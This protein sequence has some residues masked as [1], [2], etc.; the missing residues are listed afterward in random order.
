MGSDI[1]VMDQ[2]PVVLNRFGSIWTS[3]ATSRQRLLK[4]PP[5]S[6]H[7]GKKITILISLRRTVPQRP[8]SGTLTMFA[9]LMAPI[10][11]GFTEP[12]TKN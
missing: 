4:Q 9:V 7:R 11:P 12:N 6:N 2:F 3:P 8:S 5:Y 1:D 10:R